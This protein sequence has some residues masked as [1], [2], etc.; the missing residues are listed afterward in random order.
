[1]IELIVGLLTR[2]EVKTVSKVLGIPVSSIY[3]LLKNTG[4]KVK[5]IKKEYSKPPFIFVTSDEEQFR[6]W[7]DSPKPK[8]IKVKED[9]VD[10][11]FRLKE[12]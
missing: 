12:G 6:E 3:S 9:P 1:L 7:V 8:D 2:Y 5:N 4:I 10:M 11:Y